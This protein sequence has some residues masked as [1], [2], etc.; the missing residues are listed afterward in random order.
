VLL[1]I[2]QCLFVCATFY[3]NLEAT[4]SLDAVLQNTV[5]VSGTFF[6]VLLIISLITSLG[7]LDFLRDWDFF[8]TLPA[9]FALYLAAA[10]LFCFYSGTLGSVFFTTL[11]TILTNLVLYDATYAALVILEPTKNRIQSQA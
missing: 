10:Q 4:S 2:A 3:F 9:L 5:R 11:G 8:L 1:L 6:L 7:Y